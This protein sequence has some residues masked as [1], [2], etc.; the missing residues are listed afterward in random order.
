MR[1]LNYYLLAKEGLIVSKKQARERGLRKYFTGKLCRC[2]HLAERWIE[3]GCVQCRRVHTGR[4]RADNPLLATWQGMVRRCE[5]PNNR[6]F[7][8]YGGRLDNP[9]TVCDRWRY[10]ENSQSGDAVLLRRHG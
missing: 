1:Q 2:G 5:D 9:I 6:S 3:G 10:G 7:K 8:H 4:Y